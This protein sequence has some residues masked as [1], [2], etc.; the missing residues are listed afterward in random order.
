[1][2]EEKQEYTLYWE[3]VGERVIY[4]ELDDHAWKL[5]EKVF[6]YKKQNSFYIYHDGKLAAFYSKNDSIKEAELGYNFY[7]NKKN[8]LHIIN[9]K[10]K[11]FNNVQEQIELLNKL[12]PEELTDK[13][14]KEIILQILN[15]YH[16]A[17]SHHYLTQPQFFEKFK[18]EEY[19]TYKEQFEQ[20]A[21]ARFDY[22]R[23]AWTKAMELAKVFLQE[24]AKRKGLSLKEVENLRY[25]ELQEDYYDTNELIER[26]KKFVLI[27]HN[28]DIKLITGDTV[29]E[30]IKRYEN[31]SN[32]YS[33]KGTIGNK[34]KAQ[35]LAF[36]VK[37]ENLDLQNLPKGMKKGMVL[38][39]QNAWPEFAP[40]YKLAAAIV[41]NEGGIT[42]HGVVV[43]RE[44]GV[45]C[46]VATKIATKIFRNGDLVKVDA[47]KGIV[48]K[49]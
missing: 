46:L 48:K 44:F 26:E 9:L 43:A 27:S 22:T 25:K 28:H 17:L 4:A 49:L 20:I 35:G 19:E 12:K 29:N 14:L 37:N 21:K 1:M 33:L 47:E 36:V 24:Y 3:D 31:Y 5:P 40:Y 11:I 8:Y 45:P 41:T 42:S 7:R 23:I 32:I 39:V 30:Y 10:Q 18:E 38:I 16:E 2:V 15:L 6:K 34:G 13:Q